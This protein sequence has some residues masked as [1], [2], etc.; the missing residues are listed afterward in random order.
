MRPW[1]RFAVLGLGGI[2]ASVGPAR[3]QNYDANLQVR[4]GVFGQWGIFRGELQQP[5]VDL[6]GPG[7]FERFAFSSLGVGITAG[8]EYVRR[9]GWSYGIEVD[10]GVLS[11]E[12]RTAF[13]TYT[14][15]YFA[16][17]R[18]R[19]GQHWRPD[20]FVYGTVGIGVLG[21]EIIVPGV[22]KLT[23][24][25]A[26]LA[27]GFGVERDFGPGLWFAEYLFNDYGSLGINAQEVSFDPTSHS[28]RVGIKFKV[29]HDHYHD[30]VA[31]RIG[32]RRDAHGGTPVK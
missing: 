31:D 14:P 21:A 5:G 17:V 6:G 30:D 32:R 4:S 7:G 8:L 26:G 9:S 20:V 24:S 10:G 16:S 1:L 13:A 22:P 23:G 27:L 2:L 11:G 29:G 12:E 15:N 3:A 28:L 25:K 19:A 18:L